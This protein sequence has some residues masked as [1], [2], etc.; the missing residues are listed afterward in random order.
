MVIDHQKFEKD[1]FLVFESILDKDEC[2]VLKEEIVSNYKNNTKILSVSD[3]HSKLL[4]HPAI[5]E[6]NDKLFGK[7]SFRFHHMH[8]TCH[9]AG[10]PS[11]GWH[12][13]YEEK[14]V[15]NRDHLMVH[16]LIYL[17]GLNGTI[18][19]L[20]VV[21][22]SHKELVHHKHYF[23]DDFNVFT[24]KI[25]IND[26]PS[27]SLVLIH[28]GLIHGRVKKSGGEGFPRYFIDLSYCSA[29]SFWPSYLGRRDWRDVLSR[30]RE[31]D[32]TE[33]AEIFKE[34]CFKDSFYEIIKN[35]IYFAVVS[36]LGILRRIFFKNKIKNE[37]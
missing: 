7:K 29:N 27:G 11:L 1:G 17:T 5:M 13:D 6:I 20:L 14:R 16:M 8:S 31:S 19:D 3:N 22:G 23:K 24:N 12:H 15:S 25:T 18:G 36:R 34:D 30:L 9:V 21:P 28:S 33:Y 26:L 4:T 32:K 10:T 37:Y 35:R 2:E